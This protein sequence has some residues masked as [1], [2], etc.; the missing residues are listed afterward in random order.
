MAPIGLSELLV[1]AMAMILPCLGLLILVGIVVIM[2]HLRK[3]K[4]EKDF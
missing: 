2:L 1:V 3:K 4:G